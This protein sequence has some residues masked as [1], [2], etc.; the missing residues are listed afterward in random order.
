MQPVHLTH[1]S[2]TFSPPVSALGEHGEDENY[3]SGNYQEASHVFKCMQ[4][5]LQV[6]TETVEDD[7]NASDEVDEGVVVALYLAPVVHAPMV[8][9]TTAHVVPG[10]GIE[11]D[12]FYARSE[13]RAEDEEIWYE[14]TLVEQEAID[15]LG[16]EESLID[17]GASVRRN[18]VV[19]G[20]SLRHLV[21]HLF[22][23]GDVMFRGFARHESCFS[24]S[25]DQA[26]VCAVLFGTDLGAQVLTEGTL[27]IGDALRVI[28]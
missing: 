23:I 14:V 25:T 26:D 7:Q 24:E 11:G 13:T 9:I 3:E 16:R 27:V 10:R 4:C 2:T 8:P 21:G 22:L 18:I 12:R 17:S 28:D 19:R 5:D 15:A 20:C 6:Q 1:H